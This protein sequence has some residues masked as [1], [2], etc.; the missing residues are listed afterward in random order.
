MVPFCEAYSLRSAMLLLPATHAP[1]QL[2]T[3]SHF[4]RAK[5]FPVLRSV[6]ASHCYAVASGN[7]RS[8]SSPLPLS[9]LRARSAKRIRFAGL[10]CC[11]WQPVHS[12]ISALALIC[13]CQVVFPAPCL[14]ALFPVFGVKSS[15]YCPPIPFYVDPF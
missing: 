4:V 11:F 13:A 15:A 6:F 2:R 8:R 12:F 5:C 3:R 10:C 1:A 7:A 9:F 14:P